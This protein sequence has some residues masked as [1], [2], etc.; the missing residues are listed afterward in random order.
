MR[1]LNIASTNKTATPYEEMNYQPKHVR[2]IT[3]QPS[4]G[5][6][7]RPQSPHSVSIENQLLSWKHELSKIWDVGFIAPIRE[8]NAALEL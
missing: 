8:E 5:M 4:V 3:N 2:S 1:S 6:K 7:Y